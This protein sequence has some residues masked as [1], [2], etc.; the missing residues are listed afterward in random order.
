VEPQSVGEKVTVPP[1]EI[2]LLVHAD[3]GPEIGL[4][5]VMRCLTL[6]EALGRRAVFLSPG[7][8]EVRRLVETGGHTFVA[9]AGPDDIAGMLERLGPAILIV[10]SYRVD[11]AQTA[12]WKEKSR[13]LVVIDDLND[14]YLPADLVING[15]VYAEEL[16]YERDRRLLLGPR[17]LLLRRDFQTQAAKEIV[18][19]AEN[20]LVT[21]GGS[22]PR[23]LTP[24]IL[25]ILAGCD[26][27]ARVAVGPDFGGRSAPGE[28]SAR[29][30]SADNSSGWSRAATGGDKTGTLK[31]E[32]V[33]K[34]DMAS[35]MTWAD[36]AVSAGGSTLYELCATG[37]PALAVTVAQNQV[38][39]SR[40]LAARGCILYW[41]SHTALGAEA[42][43]PRHREEAGS[44][45]RRAVEAMA[46]D[47]ARRTDMSSRGQAL[48]D[49]WG[50]AR[51]A[52]VIAEMLENR[53]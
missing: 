5:H 16:A 28:L 7:A 38:P 27:R 8:E 26:L 25:E 31:V 42:G 3:S 11:A 34:P 30:G 6:V 39:A 1:R 20:L 32:L 18:P 50:A 14:R 12:F 46:L 43:D 48:V 24:R 29:W 52:A 33:E 21:F 22:D 13:L 9:V 2:R 15:N 35:L 37:T 47:P 17:Y 19:R 44:D 36:M 45:L 23:E 53:I 40:S 10:D 51:C 41:G 4:G 49:G